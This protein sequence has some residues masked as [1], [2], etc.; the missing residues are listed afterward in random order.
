[1]EDVGVAGARTFRRQARFIPELD[2]VR[3]IAIL[4]V[5]FFHYYTFAWDFT[6]LATPGVLRMAM[7]MGFSGVDLFFVLSGFLISGILLDTAG[8]RNYFSSFYVRRVLR[9]FPLY[10]L[11]IFAYFHVALPLAHHYGRWM[12]WNNSLE[13]WYWFHLSNWKTAFGAD[14]RGPLTQFWSLSVEEQFYLVW[15]LVVFLATRKRLPYV[16]VSIILV[17]FGLRCYFAQ[18]KLDDNFLY[19]LTPFRV[20][21]LAFGCLT[22]LAV[23]NEKARRTVK[24]LLP[25]IFAVGMLALSGALWMGQSAGSFGDPMSTS[26]M[27]TFGLTSLA[28]LYSGLVFF[29]H[30]CSLASARPGWLLRSAALRSFGKYS[31][32]IYVF[33]VPIFMWYRHIVE[34]ISPAVPKDLRFVA[35]FISL[36]MEIGLCYAMAQVSWY[37]LEKRFLGLK[38]LVP[39]R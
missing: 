20:E 31:Y 36:A 11:T 13:M 25:S 29:A 21:P 32:A 18:H 3:G 27:A 30:D 16:C 33:H 23:R 15:P 39:A 38:R 6:T 34:R 1:M 9:I 37:L 26:P 7:A 10:L 5:L 19:R 12:D 35:W 28:V 8:A 22:A 4:L 17:S 14:V 2:G 24:K